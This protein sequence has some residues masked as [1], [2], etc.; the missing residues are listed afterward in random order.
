MKELEINNHK[1]L[2]EKNINDCFNYEETKSLATD[3]FEE[4]DFIFGDY[5]YDKLRLKGFCK[6]KNKRWNEINDIET[7]EDYILNY[8]SYKANYFLLKKVS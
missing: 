8:C 4:F 5:S 7:I 2:L 6:K 3:Y 1:Y